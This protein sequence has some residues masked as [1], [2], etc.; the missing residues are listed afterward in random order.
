MGCWS[1]DHSHCRSSV[2]V[3]HLSFPGF[4]ETH[5]MPTRALRPCTY[6]GCHALTDHGSRCALHAKLA[7]K[8]R[9][10]STQRGYG[11]KYRIKRDAFLAKNPWCSDPF[12]DHPGQLVRATHC[13]HNIPLRDGGADDES[14]YNALCAHCHNKKT[15][16]IDGGFGNQKHRVGGIKSLQPST[17]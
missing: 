7:D 6:P 13:D 17:K 10:T 12:G 1:S 15:P 8:A 16:T 14:N 4:V 5:L 3:G 2:V 11:H 9:G